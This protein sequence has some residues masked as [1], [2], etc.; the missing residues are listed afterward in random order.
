MIIPGLAKHGAAASIVVVTAD[1]PIAV[2]HLCLVAGLCVRCP[3]F[4][5]SQ[6]LLDGESANELIIHI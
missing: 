5:H 1:D 3:L 6:L 4:P 2:P